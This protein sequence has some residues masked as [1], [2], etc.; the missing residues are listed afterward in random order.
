M[1]VRC[2]RWYI[3]GGAG[4]SVKPRPCVA[5]TKMR[6]ATSVP[7]VT[8]VGAP[9]LRVARA[10]ALGPRVVRAGPSRPCVAWAWTLG[11]RVAVRFVRGAGWGVGAVRGM[12]TISEVLATEEG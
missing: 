9:G 8:R 7:H 5:Q 4:R 1:G 10:R 3:R 6:T 12:A 11:P 2:C